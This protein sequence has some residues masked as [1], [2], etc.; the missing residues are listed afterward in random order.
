LATAVVL[1]HHQGDVGVLRVAD[2]GDDQARALGVQ[3]GVGVGVVEVAGHHRDPLG[4]EGRGRDRIRL[5]H[6]VPDPA[7]DELRDQ[8]RGDV[9]V[10]TQEHVVGGV[11]A[12]LARRLGLELRL[13]P[14]GVEVP[15][16]DEGQHDQQQHD[17]RE[18]H[19]DAEDPADVRVERDV[20]EPERAHHG[21][22]PVEA[23][24]PGVL[25]PLVEHEDV[26]EDGVDRDRCREEAEVLQQDAD[27][28]AV[29]GAREQ[30]GELRC[31]ELHARSPSLSDD[32]GTG[33][34]LLDRPSAMR[35]V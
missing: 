22:G 15:D 28:R 9:V 18:E 33:T 3:P 19:H 20:A 27:V 30:V 26:E 24:Q 8:P 17:A 31:Q 2:V 5:D 32:T 6:V 29:L 1:P 7:L 21:E 4:L 12:G 35:A 25:L 11:L 10:V 14:G 13:E 34:P 23:G 16:E